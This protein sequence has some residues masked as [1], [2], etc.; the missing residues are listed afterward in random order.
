MGELMTK[1][2]TL[3]D[4]ILEYVKGYF[5]KNR[6]VPSVREIVG[7]FKEQGLNK[8]NIYGSELFPHGIKE[9]YELAMIPVPEKL[10]QTA[11]ALRASKVSKVRHVTDGLENERYAEDLYDL[12]R[13]LGA[14]DVK[15]ALNIA[16]SICVHLSPYA[17]HYQVRNPLMA[18]EKIEKDRDDRI[19]QRADYAKTQEERAKNAEARA[20]KAE[21]ELRSIDE[22]S[23]E[24]RLMRAGAHKR[25][26]ALYQYYQDNIGVSDPE[27][28]AFLSSM[29]DVYA[30]RL[31]LV[32]EEYYDADS[33]ETRFR[34][35]TNT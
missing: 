11:E 23:P 27:L 16:K 5:A 1:G 18:L 34:F 25:V 10:M 17:A 8:S 28:P 20:D 21:L 33:R 31:G 4:D 19:K 24:D 32:I 15:E 2:S 14:K 13:I 30:K 7:R 29:C 6:S 22:G 26:V 35:Y 3:R 9:I 12:Q